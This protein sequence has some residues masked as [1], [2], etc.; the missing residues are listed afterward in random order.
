MKK[1]VPFLILSIVAS[2]V[3]VEAQMFIPY[4]FWRATLTALTIIPNVGPVYISLGSTYTFSA[5]GGQGAYAFSIAGAAGGTMDAVLGDYIPAATGTETATVTDGAATT[6]SVSVVVYNPLAI[7]PTTVTMSVNATQTFTATGGCLNGT[8]CVGGAYTWSVV[9]GGGS[10]TTAGVFT[11]PSGTATCVV[12]VAD[13]IGNVAQSTVTVVNSLTISPATLRLAVYST[14]TFTTILGTSPYTYSVFAG[15][16]TNVGAVYTAPAIVGTGTFRVTDSGTPTPGSSDSTITHV[17]PVE[18]KNGLYFTCARYNEGS[19]K[20][21]GDNANGQLGIGSTS[22][23]GDATTEVG[24]ANTFVN[25][26][27]GVTATQ[28]V[29]GYYHVCALLNTGSVKCWGNNASGQLG[30]G[31]TTQVGSTSVN[32]VA[33]LAAINFGVRTVSTIYAF[34]NV[35]CAK[36]TNNTSVCWGKNTTGQLGEGGSTNVT[37]PSATAIDFGVG[38]TASKITGGLD[39]ACAILDDAS[40]KCWGKYRYGQIGNGQAANAFLSTPTATSTLGVGRTAIDIASG[41]DHTCVILD[42]ATVKCWGRNQSG[43]LGDNSTTNSSVPIAPNAIG[44]GVSLIWTGFQSTCVQSSVGAVKCWGSNNYG[45]QLLVGGGTTD[46]RQPGTAI[47]F[48]TSLVLSKMG[49]AYY[50]YCMITTG[51]RI[52]CWGRSTNAAGVSNGVFLQGTSVN[53]LGDLNTGGEQGDGL[54]YLNH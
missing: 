54:P 47:N 50:T 23:I 48:G 28:I 42:D 9:S 10:I 24:G 43:N 29:T 22:I 8:N 52:K 51:D 12:Q 16:G 45:E 2:V 3:C 46:L 1:V 31:N 32:D 36:F 30:Q 40:V 41:Y 44:F 26:G 14:S 18:I 38:R 27:V 5:S 53:H 15:T 21:W 49:V 25:L 19:V 6:S 35:S 20:C 37:S 4:S 13:S 33:N 39:F 17:K 11:A 34:G 7:S